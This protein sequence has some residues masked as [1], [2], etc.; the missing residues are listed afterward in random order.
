M[1]PAEPTRE[2]ELRETFDTVAEHH[3][4]ARPT[5]PDDLPDVG[6]IRH[7][8]AGGIRATGLFD[9]EDLGYLRVIGCTAETYI[10]VLQTY[11]GHVAMSEEHWHRPFAGVRRLGGDRVIRKD[12][13][14]C[15]HVGRRA[16]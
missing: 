3:E 1:T 2:L 11:S 10:D 12:H 16:G 5:D 6:E 9:V 15:L 13:L 4:R 8:D 7:D 14:F